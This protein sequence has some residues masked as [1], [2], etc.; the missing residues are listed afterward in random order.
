M[1]R[2]SGRAHLDELLAAQQEAHVG[3]ALE[4]PGRGALALVA[5]AA[6]VARQHELP[7]PPPLRHRRSQRRLARALL[8][9]VALESAARPRPSRP[10]R[11]S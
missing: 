1:F 9:H 11:P 7:Q 8:A 5:R 3:M 10:S 2:G 4:Q 6:H